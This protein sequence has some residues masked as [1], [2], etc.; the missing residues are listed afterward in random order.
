MKGCGVAASLRN[1]FRNFMIAV[2]RHEPALPS[3]RRA[4]IQMRPHALRVANFDAAILPLVRRN[5]IASRLSA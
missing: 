2:D 1:F 5:E 4:K 3:R